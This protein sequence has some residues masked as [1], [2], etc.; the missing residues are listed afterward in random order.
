MTTVYTQPAQ[1]VILTT[2]T[3]AFAAMLVL[4]SVAAMYNVT[5]ICAWNYVLVC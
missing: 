1:H 2:T 5:V 3:V 4:Y